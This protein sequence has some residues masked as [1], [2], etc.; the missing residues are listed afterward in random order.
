MAKSSE[1]EVSDVVAAARHHVISVRIA[2]APDQR[3]SAIG[4]SRTEVLPERVD[5][6]LAGIND[7]LDRATH[8]VAGLGHRVLLAWLPLHSFRHVADSVACRRAEADLI[9]GPWTD[10]LVPAFGAR[11]GEPSD[12]RFPAIWAGSV[13]G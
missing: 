1:H 3:E 5:R 10:A 11:I 6:R 2:S 8:Q 7:L 4:T 13:V 9:G 12:R